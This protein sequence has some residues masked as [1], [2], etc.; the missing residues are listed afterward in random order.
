MSQIATSLRRPSGGRHA[1]FVWLAMTALF[2]QSLIVQTHLHLPFASVPASARG[3]V[4]VAGF[5]TDRTG[6]A[7]HT[8]CPLCIELKAAGHYL[9]S[10]PAVLIAPLVVGFWFH[11]MVEFALTRPQPTHHWQSRAPPLSAQF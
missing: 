3:A 8:S 10:T 1:L 4:A 7:G 5:A 11:R 6:P 2:L 9:P